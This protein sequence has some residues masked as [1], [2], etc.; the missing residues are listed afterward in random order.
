MSAPDPD[1]TTT[2]R[3]TGIG[4]LIGAI[5]L[6]ATSAIGPGFITQTTSFTVQL[7]AAFA[8]AIL[9]SVLVDIAVQLNVWRVLGVSG[10]RAS[11]LGN[12]VLPGLGWFL[13]VLV[14]LGGLVFNVGNISGGG[15]GLDAMLGLDTTVG[16][17]I[18]AA[19]AIGIFLW[20]R[21]GKAMD[22]VVV[23]LGVIMI[24]LMLYVTI[25]TKPPLGEALVQSV[26]PDTFSF[27]AVTTLIGG[28]VGG[29]ITYS[30][31]HRM[32]DSGIS[33]VKNVKEI[34][35]A[36]ITGVIVTGV[37]RFLLFLAILGVVSQGVDL[38]GADNQTATAFQHAAGEFGL[39]IFGVIL[40]GAAITSVIGA[41]FT[42]VSFLTPQT[43][44]PRTRNLATV[45][46]I[47][48]S[49]IVFAA[50]GKAPTTILIVA[51]AV[52]GLILPAG[53]AL[54][55]WVAWRRRDLLQGYVYPKWLLI[56]GV[57]VWLLTLYLG[58]NSLSGIAALWNAG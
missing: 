8:A 15:L 48:V 55:L 10:M 6:M 13:A 17:L 53:F 33:G 52:N 49:S 37:M 41:A 24:L 22:V 32:L 30:G 21:A 54:I 9:I 1:K 58:Y 4:S 38:S 7:G 2:A 5:F 23:A 14:A 36:S 45:A 35:Q 25:V 16:G 11:T 18:T 57:I 42:S 46:F 34:S 20:K 47:V 43:A 44:G 40:W 27:V 12:T 28:T 3:P 29:Y 31:A 51:G 50:L 26:V 56:V 39:R 19:I